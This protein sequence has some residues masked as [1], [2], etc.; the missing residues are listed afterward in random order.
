MNKQIKFF[1]FTV[2]KDISLLN[3]KRYR[4][5]DSENSTGEN[6]NRENILENMKIMAKK[7][8]ISIQKIKIYLIIKIKNTID[9]A[10]IM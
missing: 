4:N 7:A 1:F 2:K 8:L 6:S 3:K 9:I 10:Q 5:D